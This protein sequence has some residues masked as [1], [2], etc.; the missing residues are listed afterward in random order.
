MVIPSWSLLNARESF[1]TK[2]PT[3]RRNGISMK[4]QKRLTAF[5]TPGDVALRYGEHPSPRE[6]ARV[7]LHSDFSSCG[8][9]E[10][11]SGSDEKS[12]TVR[13]DEFESEKCI[14]PSQAELVST[15]LRIAPEAFNVVHSGTSTGHSS[16]ARRA[17]LVSLRTS[18]ILG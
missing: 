7:A 16:R 17:T 8:S 10:E 12:R 13:S 2:A 6:P 11:R 4:P 5:E 9:V 14:V 18:R 1:H 3:S 15:G